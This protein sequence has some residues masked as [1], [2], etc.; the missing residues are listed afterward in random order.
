MKTLSEAIGEEKRKL[1]NIKDILGKSVIL[2]SYVIREG[3]FGPY[4]SI[5]VTV[6]GV[7]CVVNTGGE[8]VVEKLKRLK[9]ADFPVTATFVKTDLG[10]GRRFYDIY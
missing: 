7:K 3:T 9:D 4:A 5:R 6:E 10:Q 2:E 1:V 8:T